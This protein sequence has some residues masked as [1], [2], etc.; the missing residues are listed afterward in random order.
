VPCAAPAHRHRWRPPPL[1]QYET[2]AA[3][4]AA[5]V[6]LKV[7]KTPQESGLVCGPMSHRGEGALDGEGGTATASCT[8]HSPGRDERQQQQKQKQQ[9]Q[10]QQ[11]HRPR[12]DECG[13]VWAKRQQG[14]VRTHGGVKG[15]SSGVRRSALL[16]G[17]QIVIRGGVLQV[18]V[19]T[20]ARY[21]SQINRLTD[22]L[23]YQ[24]RACC[25]N[26]RCV[27]SRAQ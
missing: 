2:A 12:C 20:A 11:Q 24:T 25:C 9:Q 22:R 10:R 26:H 8:W 13:W 17:H 5:A 18:K 3:A 16:L 6:R 15:G 4:A 23:P 21:S 27:T 1:H 7:R 19:F 14:F